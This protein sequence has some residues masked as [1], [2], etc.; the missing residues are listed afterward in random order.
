MYRHWEWKYHDKWRK[1]PK[2]QIR[3]RASLIRPDAL[4]VV[5]GKKFWIEDDT[6]KEWLDQLGKFKRYIDSFE[7]LDHQKNQVIWVTDSKKRA[8]NM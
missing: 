1:D 3:D 5:H 4:L 7:P 6:G 8:K 2:R